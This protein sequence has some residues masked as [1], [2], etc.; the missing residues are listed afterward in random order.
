MRNNRFIQHVQIVEDTGTGANFVIDQQN[1]CGIVTNLLNELNDENVKIK[2]IIQDRLEDLMYE[3]NHFKKIEDI[4][5]NPA[6]TKRQI[7]LHEAIIMELLQIQREIT[8]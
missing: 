2:K 6:R 8:K 4:S 3:Y 5:A 1:V 7:D